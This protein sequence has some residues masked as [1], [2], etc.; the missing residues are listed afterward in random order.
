MPGV[1]VLGVLFFDK[2]AGIGLRCKASTILIELSPTHSLS[3]LIYF[4][5][6]IDLLL[7]KLLIF[8]FLSRKAVYVCF[9]C[10]FEIGC[11]VT[12]AGLKFAIQGG[13]P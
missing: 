11:H 3:F 1:F 2:G 4:F 13:W 5:S 6:G 9:A 7:S 12:Q 8:F 10:V